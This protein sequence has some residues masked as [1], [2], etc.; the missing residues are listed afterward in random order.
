MV[1]SKPRLHARRG[2]I[3][4]LAAAAIIAAV[5]VSP[6]F[7]QD[8]ILQSLAEQQSAAKS[9]AQTNLGTATL[10]AMIVYVIVT[11]SG[12]PGSTL[13][14][15]VSATILPLWVS[16][17]A[18]SIASTVGAT[19]AMLMSRYLL[20]DMVHSW[21]GERFERFEIAWQRD[22][23]WYLASMRVA[24]YVPFF[25][26]NLLMGLTPIK[27]RSFFIVSQLAMFPGTIV[28]LYLGSRLPP[29]Q[30]LRESGIPTLITWQ[31]AG[32]FSL[33][34]VTPL[35]IRF[36]LKQRLQRPYY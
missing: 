15:I 13:L 9:Y 16:V 32:A 11:A 33:L 4:L 35:L 3:T 7:D 34:A 1:N 28:N 8:Q 36:F 26:I 12:F 23:L 25:S 2:Y 17:F 29:L 21:F 24:P 31:L 20:R 14:S 22:G 10:I 6:W 30:E 5:W 18:V 27:T 19:I